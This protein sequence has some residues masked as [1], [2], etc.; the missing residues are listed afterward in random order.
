MGRK[1]LYIDACTSLAPWFLPLDRTHYARWLPVHI[2]DMESLEQELQATAAE[3]TKGHFVVNKTNHMFSPL[4]TDQ[5]HE[6]II[7]TS[8][9]TEETLV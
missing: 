4:P 2:R 5:A 6:Q 9:V 1:P 3:L 7:R 8:K